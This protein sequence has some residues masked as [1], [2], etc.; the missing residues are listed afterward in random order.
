MKTYA[1]IG[2]GLI[3]GSVAR[4]IR[5]FEPDSRIYA[6]ARHKETVEQAI[7]EGIVDQLLMPRDPLYGTCDYIFL[8]A[9]VESN[10]TYLEE[11]KDIVSDDCIFTDV[12]SVKSIIHKKINELGMSAHFIGGH[13]MAGSEKSGF[14]ASSD[15]LI[16]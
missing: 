4:A 3:G 8:C 6:Y 1:F 9:P 14:S 11:L 13:P 5:K 16:E 10:L 2:L 12:G 15:R 7:E